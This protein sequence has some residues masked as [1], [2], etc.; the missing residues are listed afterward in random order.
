MKLHAGLGV[1]I[2]SAIQF[3]Y[4]VVPIVRHHHENWDGSGYPDK[5]RGT[6]IP[7]GARILSVVDCYDAL[8]SD[9]PYR[10]RLP[11]AEAIAIVMQRRGSMQILSWLTRSSPNS[12]NLRLPPTIQAQCTQ[13]YSRSLN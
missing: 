8:T 11:A 6:E 5:L 10:P 13:R 7:L 2:L 12:R 1:D 4:P 3:P 9:R